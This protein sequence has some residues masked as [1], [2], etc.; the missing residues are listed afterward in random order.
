MVL[1]CIYGWLVERLLTI[2]GMLENDCGVGQE[3]SLE[4]HSAENDRKFEKKAQ[5]KKGKTVLASDDDRMTNYSILS[6]LSFLFT[7]LPSM[8]HPTHLPSAIHVMVVHVRMT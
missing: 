3:W 8:H 2:E 6:I 4:E 1:L 5:M 7:G